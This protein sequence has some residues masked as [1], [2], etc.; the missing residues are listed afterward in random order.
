[1]NR[2]REKVTEKSEKARKKFF[3]KANIYVK[4]IR[5]EQDLRDAA[6]KCTEE[7][8]KVFGRWGLQPLLY[9]KGGKKNPR[10]LIDRDEV[11][12]MYKPPLWQMG[13]RAQGDKGWQS[14]IKKLTSE[15]KNLDAAKAKIM[16][17]G[18]I[19][20]L[21]EWHGLCTGMKWLSSNQEVSDWGFVQRLDLETDGPVV[22]AKTWRA[23]SFIKLQMSEHIFGKAYMCL[24]H[25]RVENRIQYVKS[26]F[27]SIADA[28]TASAV[29]VR[30]D[31]ENDPFYNQHYN[32][33][34]WQNR[35]VRQAETFFKPIA[36]YKKKDDGSEFSLV[37]VNI[38]SGITHQVRI[39]M[40]SVGH[41]LVSD[42]R[43]LPKAEAMSDIKWCPRNFLCEVRSDWFD[44]CGPH[45]D[46]E[47]RPY[48][49]VSVENPLPKLF[50]NILEN[51]L[52]LTEKL[53]PT[54][55]LFQGC[56]YWALGDQELM[57]D[58]PK[59]RA[60][61]SKV[62][63]WGQRRG[64]HLDAMERLLMLKREDIEDIMRKYRP[65]SHPKEES[66]VCPYCMSMN[67]ADKWGESNNE[68]SKRLHDAKRSMC[69][70][71]RTNSADTTL[72]EGW[73]NYLGNPT[74][75]M[76]TIVNRLWLDARRQIFSK[77]RPVWEKAPAEVEGDFATDAQIEALHARLIE[78]ATSGGYGLQQE[79]L[80]QV[81]GL[82]NAKMPLR[83]P[84]DCP[85]R[86]VRLPARGTGSQWTYTLTGK[87]R[88]RVAGEFSFN[89]TPLKGPVEVDAD[90]LPEKMVLSDEDLAQQKAA[91]ACRLKAVISVGEQTSMKDDSRPE[92]LKKRVKAQE[93][94]GAKSDPPSK[95]QK[96]KESWKKLESTTNPGHFYY[97]NAETGESRADAPPGFEEADPVWKR[98]ESSSKPGKYYYH[99]LE[100]GES[101]IERPRGVKVLGEDSVSKQAEERH[102][103]RV[104]SKTKLGQF[105]YFN[106]KTGQN[107]VKPPTVQPPWLLLE[108]KSVKG[109]WYY[110]NED[111]AESSEHP[112]NSAVPAPRDPVSST[113]HA[114]A[115]KTTSGAGGA[116]KDRLPAGWEEKM[117]GSHYGKCYYINT[118]T[119]ETRWTR[120]VWEKVQSSTRAGEHYYQN[121]LTGEVSWDDRVLSS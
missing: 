61:R 5:S 67:T 11:W 19:N 26:R 16:T 47:R 10:Y 6:Q 82:E 58:Y 55:D 112:P 117:S 49:R 39:T 73:R 66:W 41:P 107:E 34:R 35:D 87:E 60:Y 46:P 64:I 97:I 103:Q 31:A 115:A 96:T 74:I 44:M 14:A 33:G 45:K 68:C 85:V 102:W 65:Q 83:L 52:T 32:V 29:M 27:A 119:Q 13:G 37:Y 92:G 106:S 38:L 80:C 1:M 25:G 36:Y 116:S 118:A 101:R 50:Q 81:K 84:P 109:Q 9:M 4:A 120:P 56:Q 90:E 110:W 76:L 59:D 22:I 93:S 24:V 7:Y 57:N 71:R 105:Y 100:T 30:Y 2:S 42:D 78:D 62:M 43:Y 48:T 28:N 8:F 79:E 75:H 12:V 54:A 99:N 91:E 15:T 89:V 21:Q 72:P 51:T 69:P 86:R 94:T 114:V 113:A 23:Q 40:Q 77:R 121:I 111:T 88:L 104:P 3:E 17:S 53:D 95:K 63:R 20:N 70:G 18:E 108:S 98:L